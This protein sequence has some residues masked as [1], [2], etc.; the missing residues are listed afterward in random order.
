MYTVHCI[1]QFCDWEFTPHIQ[2]TFIIC[3]VK[4]FTLDNILHKTTFYTRQFSN[5]KYAMHMPYAICNAQYYRFGTY[6]MCY[7]AIQIHSLVKIWYSWF[8]CDWAAAHIKCQCIS[9]A[10]SCMPRCILY[11]CMH[12]RHIILPLCRYLRTAII[13]LTMTNY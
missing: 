12:I 5:V 10:Y 1:L 8:K 13:I 3:I 2:N 11:S 4:Y 7:F 6:T 9:G